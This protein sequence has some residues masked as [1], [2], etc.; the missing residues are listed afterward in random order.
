[1]WKTNILRD[2]GWLMG[3][4]GMKQNQQEGCLFLDS[5]FVF[6]KKKRIHRTSD[7]CLGSIGYP[8][9]I[10]SPSHNLFSLLEGDSSRIWGNPKIKFKKRKTRKTGSKLDTDSATFIVLLGILAVHT[11]HPSSSLAPSKGPFICNNTLRGQLVL[12]LDAET[13]MALFEKIDMTSF[14]HKKRKEKMALAL[15][16]AREHSLCRTAKHK[17][18]KSK[19]VNTCNNL[20]YFSS[21]AASASC[22]SG[23][24]QQVV[25]TV[26]IDSKWS[27]SIMNRWC[28]SSRGYLHTCSMWYRYAKTCTLTKYIP[29]ASISKSIGH[30]WNIF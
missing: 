6:W 23:G 15:W 10:Y 25:S 3:T 12:C 27:G 14:Q 26:T 8:K 20:C 2:S 30:I 18:K 9:S 29:V 5:R 17:P 7:S 21:K 28:S 19:R 24:R 11:S 22:K 4:S 13:R 1:M 16:M